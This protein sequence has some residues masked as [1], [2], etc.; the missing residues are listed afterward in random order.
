MLVHFI[1]AGMD[2]LDDE[3]FAFYMKYHLGICERPDMV[4]ATN[5]ILDVFRKNG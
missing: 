2:A 1:R 5:H 3:S 4:G